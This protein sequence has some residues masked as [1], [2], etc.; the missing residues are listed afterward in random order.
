MHENRNSSVPAKKGA[1]WSLA[2]RK[3]EFHRWPRAA[4]ALW[5]TGSLEIYMGKS[6]SHT[7]LFQHFLI[8]WKDKERQP[9]NKLLNSQ[10]RAIWYPRSPPLPRRCPN[11]HIFK[12]EESSLLIFEL[13]KFLLSCIY[14][15]QLFNRNLK[16]LSHTSNM[17][18]QVWVTNR[19]Y[20]KSIPL[21]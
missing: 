2:R 19:Y 15:R 11:L 5:P 21:K 9:P 6:L 12:T 14:S 7:P 18:Q 3:R 17:I 16:Q 13:H 8:L 4:S 1:C 10:T 20:S